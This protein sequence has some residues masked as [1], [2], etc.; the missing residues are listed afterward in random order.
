MGWTY[1]QENQFDIVKL[2]DLCS[3]AGG[4]LRDRPL[5]GSQSMLAFTSFLLIKV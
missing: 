2:V 3:S 1:C 5:W 4:N